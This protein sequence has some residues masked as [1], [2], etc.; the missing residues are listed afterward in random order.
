V[1]DGVTETTIPILPSRSIDETLAFYGALGFEDDLPGRRRRRSRCRRHAARWLRTTRAT[2]VLRL[3]ALVLRVDCAAQL[4]DLPL[5]K[6]LLDE[7]D[8]ADEDHPGTGDLSDERRRIHELRSIVAA[9]QPGG[10]CAGEPPAARAH[11]A[12]EP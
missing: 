9:E 12:W 11:V 4:D 6:R 3:R 8:A 2:P 10:D 7:L 5:A 1:G